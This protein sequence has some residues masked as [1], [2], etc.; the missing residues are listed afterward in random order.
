MIWPA[1]VL[2]GLASI[3]PGRIIDAL[4]ENGGEF[5]AGGASIKLSKRI[6][7]VAASIRSD[8]DPHETTEEAPPKNPLGDDADVYATIINGWGLV[9]MA[10]E[11]A[12]ERAGLAP[13]NGRRPMEAV[14]SL[15]DGRWIGIRI[16][17]N[18]LS[19]WDVRNRVKNAGSNKVAKLGISREAAGEYYV[20]ASK[21]KKS[22][23]NAITYREKLAAEANTNANVIPMP[24]TPSD[25]PPVIN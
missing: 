5:A 6:D 14:K 2:V 15:R 9:V 1:V 21:V 3:R 19:L 8:D 18:I 4:L 24:T 10:L 25:H 23:G 11:D 12:V 16:E 20:S 22:I 13:V 7:E 17:H